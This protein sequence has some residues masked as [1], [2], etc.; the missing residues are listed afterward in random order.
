MLTIET[1]MCKQ[2]CKHIFINDI[3]QFYR[4]RF[5]L[6]KIANQNHTE[7]KQILNFLKEHLSRI[8]NFKAQLIYFFDYNL[9]S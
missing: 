6:I 1:K 9:N 2:M 5:T 8:G 3:Y 7:Q 4:H